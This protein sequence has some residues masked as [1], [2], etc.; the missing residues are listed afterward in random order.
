MAH[1]HAVKQGE[2]RVNK[3]T[4]ERSKRDHATAEAVAQKIGRG[5][6]ARDTLLLF[7]TA[8]RMSEFADAVRNLRIPRTHHKA[9]AHYILSGGYFSRAYIKEAT[10]VTQ[11][12]LWWDERS[13]ASAKR[14]ERARKEKEREKIRKLTGTSYRVFVLELANKLRAQLTKAKV[15]AQYAQLMDA[16]TRK[17]VEDKIA[18]LTEQLNKLVDAARSAGG[19]MKDITPA[20]QVLT[21]LTHQEHST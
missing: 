4:A 21:Q 16:G 15:A 2:H 20:S 10:I 7:E 1:G 9:A 12:H 11:L 5:K 14:S 8:D 3:Q 18:P 13:G 19:D 6:I 17:I